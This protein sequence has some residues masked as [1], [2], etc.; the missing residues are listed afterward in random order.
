M[1]N[2]VFDFFYESL[3]KLDWLGISTLYFDN[4]YVINIPTC[5]GY[6]AYSPSKECFFAMKHLDSSLS[7][8]VEGKYIA[9]PQY[10]IAPQTNITVAS[11]N[12]LQHFDLAQ[13]M[14]K[15]FYSDGQD[16]M[17]VPKIPTRA[18]IMALTFDPETGLA[19]GTNTVTRYYQQTKQST[20]TIFLGDDETATKDKP[21]SYLHPY[22]EAVC[23]EWQKFYKNQE[24]FKKLLAEAYG[25]TDAI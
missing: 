24:K 10:T 4:S 23:I 20:K 14:R 8:I 2:P 1:D 21:E 11:T 6:V 7:S 3:Q 25:V 22:S 16:K 9:L 19:D 13:Y 17:P 5:E 18:E 12:H 15:T